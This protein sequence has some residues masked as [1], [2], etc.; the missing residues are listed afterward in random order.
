M[1]HAL[2]VASFGQF[3]CKLE[4][5]ECARAHLETV[6]H[7]GLVCVA[8]KASGTRTQRAFGTHMRYAR[9]QLFMS[10]MSSQPHTRREITDINNM[11]QEHK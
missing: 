3:Y 11:I 5:G 4:R 2:Y 6:L 9:T 10:S 1:L 8:A 7:A